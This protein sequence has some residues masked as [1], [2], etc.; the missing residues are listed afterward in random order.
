MKLTQRAR[1]QK[2]LVSQRVLQKEKHDS[3]R[4]IDIKTVVLICN[5]AEV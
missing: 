3:F 1:V 2:S 5:I 4:Y